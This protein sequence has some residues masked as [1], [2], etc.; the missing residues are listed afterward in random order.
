[1][2]SYKNNKIINFIKRQVNKYIVKTMQKRVEQSYT[3]G[4]TYALFL[5]Y[6]KTCYYIKM[7]YFVY[8]VA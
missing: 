6:D 2:S 5:Q 8:Y 4:N 3:I 1:M 7:D